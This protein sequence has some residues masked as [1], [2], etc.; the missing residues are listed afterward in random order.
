VAKPGSYEDMIEEAGGYGS[1]QQNVV[2]II[3]LC[4]ILASLIFHALPYLLLVPD[5]ICY[6]K[7]PNGQE[8]LVTD[9]SQ[10]MPVNFCNNPNLRGEKI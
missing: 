10:C 9:E 3:M 4:I 7:M 8:F 6:E 1:F 2:N 5:F